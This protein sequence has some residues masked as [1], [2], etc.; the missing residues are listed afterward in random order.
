MPIMYM[1]AVLVDKSPVNQEYIKICDIVCPL[2]VFFLPAPLQSVVH[3][4][5]TI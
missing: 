3:F 4:A 1:L 5:F 2:K